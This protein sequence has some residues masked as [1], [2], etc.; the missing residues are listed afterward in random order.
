[1]PPSNPKSEFVQVGASGT[2]GRW[3]KLHAPLG[4]D[5][6]VVTQMIGEE[7]IARLFTFALTVVSTKKSI[8][9]GD[10]LGQSVTLDIACLRG[11]SASAQD[12]TDDDI[13]PNSRGRSDER[14]SVVQRSPAGA[15]SG[16]GK[17]ARYLNGIVTRF[18]AGRVLQN[19]LREYFIEVSPKLWILQRTSRYRVFQNMK[20]GEIIDKILG[21][22]AITNEAK[23]KRS[24]HETREYCVQYGET[25][26][27]FVT[28]LM[29]EE[30]IFYH[31]VH[32]SEK[33]TLVL[34]DDKTWVSGDSRKVPYVPGQRG[35]YDVVN[36]FAC[37]PTLIDC[38]Y[39]ATDYDFEAP[40][41][42]IENTTTTDKEPSKDKGWQQHVHGVGLPKNASVTKVAKI[43]VAAAEAGYELGE[44]EGTDPGFT[45]GLVFEI[46]GFGQPVAGGSPPTGGDV[47]TDDD[48]DDASGVG[49]MSDEALY[50]D[51]KFVVIDLHHNGIEPS[52]YTQPK[53][54]PPRPPYQN[55]FVCVPKGVPLPRAIP[56]QKPLARGPV[57]AL[58][59]G[60]S[61]SEI[62]TD[63][64]G[65]IK[66]Q[67]YWDQDGKKDETSSCFIR[68][69]QPWSGKNWGAV[70][71]PRVG[72][73][74]VV[75]FLD[76]DPDR[77]LVTGTV[78]N[79]TNLPPWTLPDK[80]TKSG[81]LTRSTK[82]GAV[83]DA[84]ELSFDD[85]KGKEVLLIHA[86]RDLTREVENDEAITVGH[87]QTTEIKNDRTTTIKDGNDTLTV[88][89]GNRAVT[90]TQG[91]AS[92][93]CDAGKIALTAAQSIKLTV[94][95]SSIELT[96][97]GI[98]LT[99]PTISA[100]ADANLDLKAA[101]TTLKGDATTT[102]EGGL[103]KIN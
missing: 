85:D 53:D 42:K 103:V 67:F 27:D 89:S 69:A 80:M 93:K 47:R 91:N 76:G 41:S 60:P 3:F 18:R 24:D 68:V 43:D 40:D 8:A 6:L 99:A 16:S 78:Y 72:M 71:I 95:G 79:G 52:R 56:P 25:D 36:E 62:H 100:K 33:H 22:H 98:T 59:V 75:Q 21:E 11:G 87:D 49:S 65:R 55:R 66:V 96:P 30:G 34:E 88:K 64:Y 2:S 15:G 17:P 50:K 10:L 81:F 32:E 74:V 9:P 20:A 90:I 97:Q 63:K 7:G 51:K 61:G 46:E 58:V 37:G 26:F 57:T 38:K 83:A 28:R 14:P 102:I 45:P 12:G 1:M 92:L 73:E 94:G 29:H 54:A 44:G 101:M 70:F 82:D 39:L 19:R 84:N 86:Q 48:E 35:V 23:L 5:A 77:P 13:S 31:F 4:D